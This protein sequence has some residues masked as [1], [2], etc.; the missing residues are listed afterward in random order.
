MINIPNHLSF[1]HLNVQSIQHKLDILYTELCDFDILAFS[2][3]W[4]NNSVPTEDLLLSSFHT[5]ERRDRVGYTYGGVILYIKDSLHYR[6]RLDLEL[7]RLEC[8]WVE[9]T[10]YSNRHILFGVFY[11]PPNSDTIYN[12]LVEDSIGL[13]IDTNISDVIITGDF[14]YNVFSPIT[15]RKII[16]ITQQFNLE[17]LIDQPTHFTEH[18]ESLIDLIF[19][20]NKNNVLYS[21]VGEHFLDQ[22]QRY[23]TPVFGL[24]K[25]Q[26]PKRHCFDRLIW[27]YD[28]GDYDS[29]RDAVKNHP[30]DNYIDVDIN[31]YANKV[32]T[33]ISD[34]AKQNIPNKTIKV[35]PLD[36]PWMTNDIRRNI[37]KRKRLYRKARITSTQHYWQK[38][39]TVRNET[40]LMIRE[41]KSNYFLKLSDKLKRGSLSSKD[42][43]KTLK[44]IT[45]KPNKIN[46]PPLQDLNTTQTTYLDKA[47]LLNDYFV[48]QTNIDDDNREA[49][50]LGPPNS[51]SFLSDLILR[52]VEVEDVLKSL[53]V[54]KAAGP[55]VI[56]NKLLREISHELSFPL[57]KLFNAS[58]QSCTLSSA[59]K[60]AHVTAIHK[61]SDASLP[62]NY[63]PI[64]LLNTT[65]KV[66][67]RLVFKHVFNH[68][69]DINFLTTAQSG[70]IPG[71]STVNQLVLIY[72][73]L[74]KALDDGLE[75]R[76]VFFD[77]SKAF[78]KILHID[79][80]FDRNKDLADG[81]VT[82]ISGGLA[83]YVDNT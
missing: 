54:D 41:A 6:R 21:G 1:I 17:Q 16:S 73:T 56:S 63:R 2:E 48:Q 24:L 40:I 36:V 80:P 52:P 74:C 70:F 79:D 61:K 42:W 45:F 22:E 25:F 64:S 49:P 26:K 11:R 81:H 50:E 72:E 8:I 33:T 55:D 46:I 23:H 78:D 77:I 47:N 68:L 32:I 31:T 62:S 3:T 57:C 9:I 71:D 20:S 12:N 38:F 15:N 10:L 75:V 29:L 43:W 83:R 5:P 51:L 60:V 66:F 58:L 35:R 13:A 53:Q 28:R 59:W 18:S 19:V 39:R 76:V 27:E 30:W 14:N 37:R 82:R 67:E 65:E 7:N 44:S 34:L 4:L 69:Q